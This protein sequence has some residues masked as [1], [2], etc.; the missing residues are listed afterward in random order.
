MSD[1]TLIEAIRRILAKG[2]YVSVDEDGELV[3][4]GHLQ[5]T[6]DEA[7]ELRPAIDKIYEGL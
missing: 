2:G 1:P 6:P 5:L 4:N 7:T 3:L